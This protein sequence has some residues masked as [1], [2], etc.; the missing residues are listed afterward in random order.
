P[1]P[2]P[3]PIQLELNPISPVPLAEL[4]ERFEHLV[5]YLSHAGETLLRVVLRFVGEDDYRTAP[6]AKGF[7]HACVHGLLW[8]SVEV[9]ETA[10]ALARATGAGALIE[11]DALVVGALLHDVAKTS[12]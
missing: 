11:V 7:H 12:E 8:H 6:A 10:L 3:H 9:A 4:T 1:L 5:G 2:T